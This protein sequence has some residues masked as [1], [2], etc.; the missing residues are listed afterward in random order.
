MHGCSF[1]RDGIS[2]AER[3]TKMPFYFKPHT[4]EWFRAMEAFDPVKAEITK[5]VIA[6]FGRMDVCSVCGEDPADDYQII[7]SFM[8]SNAVATIRLCDDCLRFR[9]VIHQETFIPYRQSMDMR[10]QAR[11]LAL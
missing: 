9:V 2:H 4:P 11:S 8:Q 10:R 3:M 6:T 1:F 7:D 5:D